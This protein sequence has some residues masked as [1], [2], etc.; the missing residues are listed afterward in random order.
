[1]QTP[2]LA[3]L[4]NRDLEVLD[5]V[6]VPYWLLTGKFNGNGEYLGTW[7]DPNLNRKNATRDFKEDRIFDK[8]KSH[9]IIEEVKD[10]ESFAR[11]VRKP[12]P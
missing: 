8:E 9:Q 4:V 11:E 10:Q 2:T 1:M 7:F 6:A 12:S 5:H 3:L